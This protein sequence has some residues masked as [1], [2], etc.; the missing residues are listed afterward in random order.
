[1]AGPKTPEDPVWLRARITQ[2]MQQVIADTSF[3][4]TDPKVQK[5]IDWLCQNKGYKELRKDGLAKSNHKSLEFN[6]RIKQFS[7]LIDV[8]KN[9]VVKAAL[10]YHPIFTQN[11]KTLC[12]NI[13][14]FANMMGVSKK[15]GF[16]MALKN[17]VNFSQ[18]PET[19]YGNFLT[20]QRLW[21]F[22][23]HGK[24]NDKHAANPTEFLQQVLQGS[25]VLTFSILNTHL[26]FV[27]ARIEAGFGPKRRSKPLRS[28]GGFFS[29]HSN[30]MQDATN[31]AVTHYADKYNR[32]AKGA[33]TIACMIARGSIEQER[34]IKA[35]TTQKLSVGF[36]VAVEAGIISYRARHRENFGNTAADYEQ[37]MKK[38]TKEKGG[39]A[40]ETMRQD[41]SRKTKKLMVSDVW[42]KLPSDEKRRIHVLHRLSTPMSERFPPE[43][44][45][46]HLQPP[47]VA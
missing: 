12:D 47:Q 5:A 24:G 32:T 21:R 20:L 39:K 26:R 11:P 45:L 28:L 46:L 16:E 8:S 35:K 41:L 9:D 30:R 34:W 17:P 14:R 43:E 6:A 38:L 15:Q 10:R 33:S 37:T 19:L 23:S 27:G 13:V 2:A 25:N 36:V 29:G 18:A 31:K 4:I 44:H 1:M 42:Q 40:A 7:R 3:T 22:T